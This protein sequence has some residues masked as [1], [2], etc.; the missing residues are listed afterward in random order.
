MAV[1]NDEEGYFDEQ[2]EP[3]EFYYARGGRERGPN[4][5]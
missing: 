2:V 3:D 5:G 1:K 4:S